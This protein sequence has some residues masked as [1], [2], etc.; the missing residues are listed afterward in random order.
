MQTD[1][2]GAIQTPANSFVPRLRLVRNDTVRVVILDTS[3]DATY[4][5][6]SQALVNNRINVST[7]KVIHSLPCMD[8]SLKYQAYEQL[9]QERVIA[10][11][12]RIVSQSPKIAHALE[13]TVAQHI[14]VEFFGSYG[15]HE[16]STGSP[17]TLRGSYLVGSIDG[18]GD[19]FD[20]DVIIIGKEMYTALTGAMVEA[21]AP[22]KLLWSNEGQV[23]FFCVGGTSVAKIVPVGMATDLPI[24]IVFGHQGQFIN[25]ELTG[26]TFMKLSATPDQPCFQSYRDFAPLR[27]FGFGINIKSLLE[28]SPQSPANSIVSNTNWE[29]RP[30]VHYCRIANLNLLSGFPRTTTLTITGIDTNL[31]GEEVTSLL[32]QLKPAKDSI[33]L[34]FLLSY[35][36]SSQIP[37]LLWTSDSRFQAP[38]LRQQFADDV[39]LNLLLEPLINSGLVQRS[40]SAPIPYI[41][42]K[43]SVQ[44]TMRELID[45]NLQDRAGVVEVL[46]DEERSAEY[47]IQRA[48]ELVSIAYP[49]PSLSNLPECEIL[50]PNALRSIG[51]GKKH[52]IVTIHLSTLVYSMALYKSELRQ[53]DQAHDWFEEALQIEEQLYGVDHVKAVVTINSLGLVNTKMQR[54]TRALENFERSLQILERT[55]GK[56]HIDTADTIDNI[57]LMYVATQRYEA[58]LQRFEEAKD[59]RLKSLGSNHSKLVDSERNLGDVYFKMGNYKAAISH[60]SEGLRICEVSFGREHLATAKMLE[61]L[62]HVY[63]TLGNHTAALTLYRRVLQVRQQDLAA[64][65]V[66]TADAVHNMGVT[67]QSMCEYDQALDLFNQALAVYRKN[68]RDSARIANALKNIAI[69]YSQHGDHDRAIEY[70]QQTLEIE[71]QEFGLEHLNTANTFSNLGAAYGRVGKFDESISRCRS[72]LDITKRFRGPWHLDVASMHHNIGMTYLS[73]GRLKAARGHL[74]KSHTIFVAALGEKDFKSRRAKKLLDTIASSAGRGAKRRW[75]T[76]MRDAMGLSPKHSVG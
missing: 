52:H 62:G 28:N 51:F 33:R 59:I 69:T 31:H 48:I 21:S 34:L 30:E 41:S 2:F 16:E 44:S 74:S 53:Y 11:P 70:F 60:F 4:S 57:G 26:T 22:H 68:S 50:N 40:I 3:V 32:R 71:I 20:F 67:F 38:T 36:D 6:L 5:E 1:S 10:V 18:K 7:A 61:N 54:H 49:A 58:A 13:S 64:D 65:Q 8:I 39:S 19:V 27:V 35:L 42:V 45:G 24:H 14:N 63:Q 47:W 17:A 29:S 37:E 56:G 46:A 73:Q 76:Y 23:V 9:T 43:D 25:H 72:A 75:K 15:G 55:F 12:G 66:E